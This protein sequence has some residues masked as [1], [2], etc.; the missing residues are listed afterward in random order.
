[1][2]DDTIQYKRYNSCIC[3]Y[4][5]SGVSGALR[6]RYK[7]IGNARVFFPYVNNEQF[8][9][10]SKGQGIIPIE[11]CKDKGRCSF[12]DWDKFLLCFS[13]EGK[14]DEEGDYLV[15][16]ADGKAGYVLLNGA[17]KTDRPIESIKDSENKFV[18]L[19]TILLKDLSRASNEFNGYSV[20]YRNRFEKGSF[21]IF[22]QPVPFDVL[23]PILKS[24]T[25]TKEALFIQYTLNV[26]SYFKAEEVSNYLDTNR[27]RFINAVSRHWKQ[28]GANDILSK[29]WCFHTRLIFEQ[30]AKQ[31]L[32]AK[33]SRLVE[34]ILGY[35]NKRLTKTD[36]ISK[37]GGIPHFST[38]RLNEAQVKNLYA[39]LIGDGSITQE[40]TEGEFLY[41]MLGIGT[42]IPSEKIKWHDTTTRLSF[43]LKEV[44]E[45][46]EEEEDSHPEWSI[47]ARLFESAKN[48]EISDKVLK[49]AYQQAM[50]QSDQAPKHMKYYHDLVENL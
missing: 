8:E 10:F 26:A 45:N 15:Y 39:A 29:E 50:N 47:A 19:Q 40:T 13:P 7:E 46:L 41:Y 31:K 32:N 16:I 24:G 33:Q 6:Y 34:M 28:D 23:Y 42:D 3:A 38:L 25:F 48:G 18:D 5:T 14:I 9:R 21:T 22:K 12:G 1:M 20:Y 2:A 11:R 35:C 49:N 36:V 4:L 37:R 17:I 43:L 44:T 30:Y 27:K